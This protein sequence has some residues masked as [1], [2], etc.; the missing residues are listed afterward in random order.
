MI[1]LI[2]SAKNEKLVI[3]DFKQLLKKII[4]EKNV[5]HYL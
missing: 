2:I 4:L 5:L 1:I 3:F